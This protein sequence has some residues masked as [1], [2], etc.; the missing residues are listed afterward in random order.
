MPISRLPAVT[1]LRSPS[2]M[3][4]A[5]PT[6]HSAIFLRSHD[7][8]R[9]KYR[10]R[11]SRATAR[12]EVQAHGWS[13]DFTPRSS[14][15]DRKQNKASGRGNTMRSKSLAALAVAAGLLIGGNVTA[16]AQD[17]PNRPVKIVI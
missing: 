2:L 8:L 7:R 14:H 12:V 11:P 17:Y 16:P 1:T 10:T 13:V 6:N 9:E 15:A 4:D 3:S 5:F